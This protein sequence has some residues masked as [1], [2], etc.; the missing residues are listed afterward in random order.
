MV[1]GESASPSLLRDPRELWPER[2]DNVESMTSFEMESCGVILYYSEL[3]QWWI[4]HIDYCE[5]QG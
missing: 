1:D 3:Y 4:A 5:R 2:V